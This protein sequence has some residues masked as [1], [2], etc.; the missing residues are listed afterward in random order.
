MDMGSLLLGLALLVV[1]VFIALRPL[2]EQQGVNDQPATVAEQLINSR[3]RVLVQLRDLDFDDA[4]GKINAD[5]YAAQR[6]KLVVEGVAILKQLDALG[7][8]S[9]EAEASSAAPDDAIE[10]AVARQRAL[11]AQPAWPWRRRWSRRVTK[12]RRPWRGRA[13]GEPRPSQPLQC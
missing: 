9:D 5:D 10:A 8:T 4:T 11:R 1:V 7:V 6:A 3:E 12:L 13:R 2:V